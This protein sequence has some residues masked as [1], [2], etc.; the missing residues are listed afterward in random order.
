MSENDQKSSQESL[1][2]QVSNASVFEYE[3]VNRNGDTPHAQLSRTESALA[4]VS[5][6]VSFFNTKL[7]SQR[8]DV[9][10]RTAFVYLIMGVLMLSIFSIYW[11]SMYGRNNRVKNLKMLVVIEDEDT[12]DG[13]PPAIGELVRSA[14]E[15]PAAK[16]RGNWQIKNTTS[17]QRAAESH[18]NTIAEEIEREIHH[19]RYWASIHVKKN[20]SL[21]LRNAIVS[22][23]TSYNVSFHSIVSHYETGRDFLAMAQVVKP[24]LQVIERYVLESSYNVI[25][26]ILANEN[27]SSTFLNPD[28]IKVAT[29]ALDFF[30]VDSRPFTDQV[31]NAP[32]QV[33]LIYTIIITFFAFNFFSDIHKSVAGMGVKPV[34]V[35]IYRFCS[36]TITFFFMSLFYSLVTLAFQVDFGKAFG[37]SGFLVYWMTNYM[38]MWSV[39]A[40][41]EAAGMLFIM[42]YP[43]LMGFWMLFWVIVNIAPTFAPM[44]LT[45]GVFRY[46]YV[47]PIFNSYQIT[48]VIFFDTYKGT[49]GRNY[50]ILAANMA[51]STVVLLIVFV[52]F[53]KTMSR[54]AV[55][56]RAKVVAE[57]RES[58]LKGRGN[59]GEIA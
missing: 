56:D 8:W 52:F 17:F 3:G 38:T 35:L 27:L 53:G 44:E 22:G 45:P 11:G 57:V 59:P 49:L 13:V 28:A 20:A 29:H 54:R 14:V 12:I 42:T 32:S 58:I 7:Q 46:G 50:G 40:V 2:P 18:N 25:D 24:S 55:A 48:K 30:Y 9:V 37:R 51:I 39:G 21:G 23:N 33:G 5:S 6:R 19:Q 26:Q 47:T 43:P 34:H 10:R 36:V 4:R 31:L 1:G 16:S 41:N 15:M